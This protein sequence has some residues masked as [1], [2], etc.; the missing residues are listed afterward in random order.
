[1]D[2][3]SIV[4]LLKKASDAEWK[5]ILKL[6]IQVNDSYEVLHG[7]ACFITIDNE[8]EDYIE[9]IVIPRTLPTV[10]RHRHGE[11]ITL[12]IFTKEGWKTVNT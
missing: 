6:Y 7:D 1:M 4:E 9:K 11:Q 8:D 10:L 3:K 12:Y 2:E 5:Y